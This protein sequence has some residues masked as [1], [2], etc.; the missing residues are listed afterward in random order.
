[1]SLYLHW[2][3]QNTYLFQSIS[4]NEI[5]ITSGS[6]NAGLEITNERYLYKVYKSDVVK[7]SEYKCKKIN[8]LVNA[9]ANNEPV[10]EKTNK[11]CIDCDEIEA[12]INSKV[13]WSISSSKKPDIKTIES[14]RNSIVNFDEELTEL[15]WQ[16]VEYAPYPIGVNK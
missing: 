4:N 9:V 10:S 8:S 12:I 2:F 14:F 11:S 5:L 6:K 15:V 1:M 13:Y 16:L 7:L 3:S